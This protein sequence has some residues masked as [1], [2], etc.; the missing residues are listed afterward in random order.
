MKQVFLFFLAFVITVISF[1]QTSRERNR[2]SR[3]TGSISIPNYT[4]LSNWA[5]HPSKWDYSDSVPAF[6][7]KNSC[8]TSVDVF[9]LHPTTYIKNLVTAS[10]NADVSDKSVND[11]T[12]KEM[13][14][15]VSVFNANCR[16]FAPRYRQAHLKTFFRYKSESSKKSFDLAYEDLKAAFQY[17]LDH[18][19]KGRPI[20]IA[21]HS[22]GSMHAIRLLREFF[23]GKEL[24][25][26]LVCAYIV[27]WQIKKDDLKHIPFGESAT[28]TGCLVGWRTYKKNHVDP[29]VK[30]EKGN[31]LCVNPVSWTADN[32]WTKSEIHKGAVGKD[33][34]KLVAQKISVAVAPDANIL[35]VHVPDDLEKKTGLPGMNNLHIADY[36]LFWMDIRENARTR[37]KAYLEKN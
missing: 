6:V 27:G 15:Q 7:K 4:D 21:S 2:S 30:R 5:A 14:M 28:Q 26:Q 9:F 32:N 24:Q 33:F 22:Q 10:L 35:W 18:W 17:Y 20:I 31:S 8:D 1:S 29:L 3:L 36:N 34:N 13:L 19:N 11:I 12:D 37:I 25:K 23:D 16:V